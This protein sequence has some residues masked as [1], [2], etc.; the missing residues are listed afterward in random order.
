[1]IQLP[2]LFKKFRVN[3]LDVFPNFKKL[4]KKT[5]NVVENERRGIHDS[6]L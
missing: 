2:L 6:K 1:M 4:K 3:L 5:K